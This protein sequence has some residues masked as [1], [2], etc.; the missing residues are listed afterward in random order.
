MLM[1]NEK[2]TAGSREQK[3]GT[4]DLIEASAFRVGSE[5]YLLDLHRVREI[6]RP[7]A[8]TPVRRAPKFVEGVIDLRGAII[9]IID[10]RKRFELEVLGNTNETRFIITVVNGRSVG[11]VVDAATDILRLPRSSIR[12]APALLSG[13]RAP[14]FLGICNYKG[15]LLTL[16]NIKRVLASEE[17]IPRVDQTEFTPQRTSR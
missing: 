12:P 16:L 1:E 15:R 9:P 10:L 11:L 6:I 4:S 8:I 5:E 2:S 7:V 17:A 3:A 14:F 13:D